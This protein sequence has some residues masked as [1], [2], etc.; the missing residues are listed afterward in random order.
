M[1]DVVLFS[2]MS[3]LRSRIQGHL[4]FPH[5]TTGIGFDKPISHRVFE[6]GVDHLDAVASTTRVLAL[7]ARLC[8]HLLDQVINLFVRPALVLWRKEEWPQITESFV[9]FHAQ[10]S[11]FRVGAQSVVVRRVCSDKGFG[12][13]LLLVVNWNSEEGLLCV[14]RWCKGLKGSVSAD[15]SSKC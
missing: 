14:I 10:W 5:T 3:R 7:F 15:S 6:R 9:S 8:L 1:D 13:Q 4:S 12:C 11:V 2:L